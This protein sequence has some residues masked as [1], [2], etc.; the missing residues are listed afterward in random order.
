MTDILLSLLLC[1]S[2]Q[3]CLD[4]CIVWEKSVENARCRICRRKSDD[5]NLLL[6][7]GCNQGFHLYCLR[8][9]LKSIPR[10][11]WFCVSCRP[12]R[13]VRSHREKQRTRKEASSSL[14][15]ES[16][17]DEGEEDDD[18]SSGEVSSEEEEEHDRKT[19]TRVQKIKNTLQSFKAS[20]KRASANSRS[21]SLC[22]SSLGKTGNLCSFKIIMPVFHWLLCHYSISFPNII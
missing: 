16:D 8:P 5:E 20:S 14:S 11:D 15:G 6:C 3:A 18:S 2:I 17:D 9:A 19:R 13:D 21:S 1:V 22:R 10:G 7:D 4:S 12:K